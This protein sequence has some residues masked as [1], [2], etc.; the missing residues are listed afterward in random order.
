MNVRQIVEHVRSQPWLSP[1]AV[2]ERWRE[3]AGGHD[4]GDNRTHLEAALAWL[5][6]AQ[7]TAGGGFARGYSLYWHPYFRARGWQPAYPET[8]GYIIPT[9]YQA[10]DQ[11]GKPELLERAERA[12]RWEIVVQL[13]SGA[14]QGGV[15]GEPVSPAVFNTGQVL[16]GWLTALARTG[17][18]RFADAALRAGRFLVD[19]LG[20]DGFWRKGHS[21]F[22]MPSRALYN[23]RTAWALAEAGTRL[24]EPAFIAAARHHFQA[25]VALLHPDGWLPE[26]CL[27]DPER[28]FLHT[29]AYAV[30]GLLEGGNL[31]HDDR[32]LAGAGRAATSLAS[33]VRADGSM[34]GRF[35]AGWVPG[36][37]WSCLTG[38]AQMANNWMR[39]FH[40]TGDRAWL[41]PVPRVIAFLKRTQNRTSA[42]PGLRGGI[43]GS[44]PVSGN[45]GRY[46]VLNW[47]T[48]YFA[49]ALIRSERLAADSAAAGSLDIVLA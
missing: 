34:A 1:I 47:A 14:V 29:L 24:G 42:D 43:K 23:A 12:A 20:D 7:D 6:R 26:C 18:A 48:K 19:A 13:P 41:E 32:L 4:A 25:V 30:R 28:P 38:Q 3:A 37:K 8:T 40:L 45:Y 44:A 9:L 35:A 36:A 31:L 2:R 15:I 27:N 11:L 33:R 49:D 5:C 39:L 10:A 46:E 21:Q 17:D 22:A 16:F